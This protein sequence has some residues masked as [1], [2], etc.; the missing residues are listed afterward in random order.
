MTVG[1]LLVACDGLTGGSGCGQV[2]VWELVVVDGDGSRE[3]SL[4]L[5]C[6]AVE[7]LPWG[8]CHQSVAAEFGDES[9][10]VSPV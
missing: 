2:G 1:D 9:G 3:D 6:N 8:L 10:G 4:S 7:T 5:G